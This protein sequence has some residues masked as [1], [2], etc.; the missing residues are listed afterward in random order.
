V[1]YSNVSCISSS[2]L[3]IEHCYILVDRLRAVVLYGG[4]IFE[5]SEQGMTVEFSQREPCWRH[6]SGQFEIAFDKLKDQLLEIC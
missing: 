4:N 6:T 2:R 1:E 3:L 5:W